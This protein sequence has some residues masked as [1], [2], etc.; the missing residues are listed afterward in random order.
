[1]YNQVNNDVRRQLYILMERMTIS[2][3]APLGAPLFVLNLHET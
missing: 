1:M 2:V 3:T